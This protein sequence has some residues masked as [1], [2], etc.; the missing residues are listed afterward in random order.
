MLRRV[1][2]TMG[3]IALLL[4]LVLPAFELIEGAGGATQVSTSLFV[5]LG[6]SIGSI[7]LI[8]NIYFN[9]AQD[10]RWHI[11]LLCIALGGTFLYDLVLYSDAVLFRRVSPVLFEARPVVVT[12]AAPLIAIGAS[13]QRHWEIPI[14]VSRTVVFHSATLMASGIFLLGLAGAGEVFRRNGSEWGLVA[15]ISLISGGILAVAVMLTSGS[16]RSRLRALLVD[17]FFT[18]RYDYRQEWMR[19]IGTLSTAETYVGLHTRVIRAVAQVVDSPGGALFVRDPGGAAFEWAGSWNMPAVMSPVPRDHA[20]PISFGQ[21]N[22][23]VVLHDRALQAA[24]VGELPRAW[25]AVPLNHLGKLIGFVVVARPRASFKLDQ[26]V[27]DLLRVIGHEVASHVAEQRANRVLSEARRLN[28]YSKRFAFVVHDIKNVSGQLSMLLSNAEIHAA[29]PEFQRDML[30]TVRAAVGRITGTLAKL[31][32]REEELERTAILPVDRLFEIATFRQKSQ[33]VQISIEHDGGDVAVA[34]DADNFD[35][36]LAHLI[37]N[38]IEAMGGAGPVR[39]KIR[40]ES[41]SVLIDVIDRGPGMSPEFIRDSLFAPLA[42]TKRTGHGIGAYQARELLR[43]AGG[44][45]LVLSRPGL[46][47][48]MRVLLP[49]AG[50][51]ARP[52]PV[53]A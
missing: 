15:E 26:E 35:A 25:L 30:E 39:I 11:N 6:F 18:H 24:A 50:I 3:L 37:D 14:H 4:I 2:V 19:C 42:S 44:D 36:V 45:L 13:R 16:A 38:A 20:L 28:D 8:E 53:T 21:A 5:R 9:T 43:E 1:F 41:S 7:L 22:A 17:H 52:A 33:D 27:F 32:A 23:V 49:S 51:P 12:L 46:G 31:Q 29:D 10:A 34:I 47:T 48:T 40:H